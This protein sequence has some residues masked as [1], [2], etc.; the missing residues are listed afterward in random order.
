MTTTIYFDGACEYW[1][2]K[3]NPGGIA[4]YG[5]YIEK[6]G[7]RLA[8]GYGEAGRGGTI[9]NNVAE[10]T[11]LIEAVKA[12]ISLNIQDD[13]IIQGDSQLVI[14]QVTGLWGC[15]KPHLERLCNEAEKL[16]SSLPGKK[17]LRWIP[18]EQNEQADILSK[19]A[20]KKSLKL[21]NQWTERYKTPV[22]EGLAGI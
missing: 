12:A 17:A 15:N 9:S 10:Y 16:V 22:L 7:Q 18:R 20:Y 19:A 3:R 11:A 2:G 21:T 4:T 14:N 6:Q 8:W 1:Q 5:W 13:L